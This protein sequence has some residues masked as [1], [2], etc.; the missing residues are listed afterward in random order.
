MTKILNI[1][2]YFWPEEIGSAPYSTDLAIYLAKHGHD[3]KT[4]A[5]RP[6][7]PSIEQFEKWATGV[8]D[9]ETHDGV[10]IERVP[11]N[12]RGSGGFKGRIRNDLRLLRRLI[13]GAL[14]G[15][16][17]NTEVIVAYVPSIFTLFGAKAIRLVTGAQIIAVVHDIESGLAHSLGITN[18][19]KLLRLMRFIERIGLNF[20]DRVVVLSEGM[21]QELIGIGCKKPIDIISIWG[22]LAPQ[23]EIDD[24]KRPILL[25][26]G[27][28]GKKQNIDQLF[29]LL[30]RLTN[31]GPEVDVIMRGGGSE[32]DRIEN[33]VKK[34]GIKNV[35]F[36]PLVP[37]KEF[38]SALQDANI[39]LVPQAQNVANYALPSK[40]FS[41][42]SAGRAFVCVASAD[43]PL[44][45]LT[46]KSQAGLCISP[47]DDDRLYQE[48]CRLIASP[49][50]QI[51]MG[52]NGR[53]FIDSNMNRN[54]ILNSFETL[55]ESVQMDTDR[56]KYK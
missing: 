5:F 13:V 27:N 30:E 6:H 33:E 45:D 9:T 35:E 21:K 24:S 48:I 54:T 55:I 56:S 1:S 42:M 38:M 22:V 34:R 44:S 23:K 20:S 14:T 37:A 12:E 49:E 17:K 39:H 50:T 29:P 16:F 11:V 26:S 18:S 28:F 47:G 31:E 41:I 53:D 43:S 8:H 36:L 51:Q 19:D 10:Q 40:L 3:V 32:R 7:Y 4:V 52:K 46:K 25:Y 2:P 15:R